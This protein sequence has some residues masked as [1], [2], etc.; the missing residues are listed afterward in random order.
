LRD[1]YGSTAK[2][3]ETNSKDAAA[4][5]VLVDM[6]HI[7]PTDGRPECGQRRGRPDRVGELSEAFDSIECAYRND[8]P[9]GCRFGR[10]IGVAREPF[11]RHLPPA[12]L[13]DESPGD[14]LDPAAVGREVVGD[15]Q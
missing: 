3:R 12:E 5:E 4:V 14:T 15:G 2:A 8:R 9:I 11:D 10:R 13:L 7:R 1:D 6:D